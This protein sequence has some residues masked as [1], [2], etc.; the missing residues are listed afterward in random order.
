M[1]SRAHDVPVS[2]HGGT[3]KTLDLIRR[4]FYWP[5][6][7]RDVRKYI[8]ACEI[9]K[10]T[11]SP[12]FTMKPPMGSQN[13]SIRPFQRLYVDLLGPYPR[14]KAGAIGLL[15][16]LDHF[17]KFH[18]LCPMRKFTSSKIEEFLEKHIFHV[19]GVPET[20][21]SDNGSQFKAND[22]NAFLTKYG[23][24]HTFTAYYSP[25]ANASE[26]VNRSLIAGIRAYVK[27]DHRLWDENVTSISCGLR[28][29]CHQSINTS[30]YRAL[31]GFH[32]ITHGS[33]Y[34]L[35]KNLNLLDEPCAQLSHEDY[36]QNI[37]QDI[38][39][40]IKEAYERNKQQYNLRT[41]IPT[42]TTGQ[43]ILRRN[44]VQSNVGR[45]FNAK[46]APVFIKARIREILGRH[47]YILEDLQGK[48]VGTFHAKD[49][50]S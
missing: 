4:K 45:H 23:I 19:Y 11:K 39:K 48:I 29:A 20:I 40:C 9:C 43:E 42:F 10:T 27:Q 32:M 24:A 17:S 6:M 34:S 26:R 22:F 38:G 18:W 44:F 36:M 28:N 47:Y 31:F 14:S 50:R 5:G 13:I 35:L 41:R 3:S 49:I 33:S 37:R 1:I 21:V 15:I 8:Q 46:L 30:P 7:V 16:V 25:Q 12:N 2:T